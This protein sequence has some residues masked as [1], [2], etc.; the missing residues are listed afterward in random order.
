VVHLHHGGRREQQQPPA[1]DRAGDR[2]AGTLHIQGAAHHAW[3]DWSIDSSPLQLPD[4]RLYLAWSG[5]PGSV[6]GVQNIYIARFANP[7]L[8]RNVY[9]QQVTWSADGFPQFGGEPVPLT[10]PL[11]LPSGDPGAP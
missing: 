5:W 6:N 7:G 10:T 3:G 11:Q 9:A 2:S 4:G 8:E 1:A